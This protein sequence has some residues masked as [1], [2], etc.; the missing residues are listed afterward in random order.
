MFVNSNFYVLWSKQCTEAEEKILPVDPSEIYKNKQCL[1][2]WIILE[3]LFY[4]FLLADSKAFIATKLKFY[5][6]KMID[7]STN[8]VVIIWILDD[9]KVLWNVDHFETVKF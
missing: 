3:R 4:I 2:K 7:V 5:I 9:D 6:F 1:N 8:L